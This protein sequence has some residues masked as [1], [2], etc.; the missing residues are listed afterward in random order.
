MK[1]DISLLHDRIIEKYSLES[2]HVKRKIMYNIII[3][4][5]SIII[6][7]ILL[8]NIMI[9]SNQTTENPIFYITIIIMLFVNLYLI[10]RGI[11]IQI[12]PVYTLVVG[13]S[14][15]TYFSKVPGDS[16]IIVIAI[17]SFTL[18]IWLFIS[19]RWWH[20]LIHLIN[21]LFVIII[22]LRVIFQANEQGI[23]S[24]NQYMATISAY[25]FLIGITIFG[26]LI[27]FIM[28]REINYTSSEI[29]DKRR[30]KKM[31]EDLLTIVDLDQKE[32][33]IKEKSYL[34]GFFDPLTM[35]LNRLLLQNSL[36]FR[37]NLLIK[38]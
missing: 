5:F 37:I 32:A 10:L 16:D 19:Y 38:I 26:I 6:S 2:I 31:F 28:E 30:N 36:W 11:T 29:E 13:S 17:F 9:H 35:C 18:M 20:M 14:L 3:I 4:F 25:I 12:V 27:Y 24:P 22:R 15:W 21:T 33:A 7:S 1:L 34:E 8:T 23:L